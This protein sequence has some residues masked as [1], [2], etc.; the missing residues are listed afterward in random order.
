LEACHILFIEK[1]RASSVRKIIA[2]L[3]GKPTLTVSDA[4]NFMADGGM[5]QLYN[6]ND[7]MRLEIN[8]KKSEESSL[9]VSAKLLNLATI[10]KSK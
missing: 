1:Q 4:D 7:K 3:I 9:T 2:E 8:P 5:I 10:Y 6:D